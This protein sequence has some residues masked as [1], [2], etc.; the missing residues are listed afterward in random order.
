M[1][2]GWLYACFCA[3]R[4]LSFRLLC[5]LSRH[6]PEDLESRL[7]CGFDAAHLPNFSWIRQDTET[8][9]PLAV[10]HLVRLIR[11]ETDIRQF[12]IPAEIVHPGVRYRI[13]PASAGGP[14]P[15]G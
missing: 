5:D 8:I 2:H 10:Q 7:L 1:T 13:V 14:A 15:P 9:S 12:V 11:K 4:E 3:N 6:F